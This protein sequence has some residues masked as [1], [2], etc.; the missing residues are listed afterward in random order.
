MNGRMF[1]VFAGIMGVVAA[2][3]SAG[4]GPR[5]Q[6]AVSQ[7]QPDLISVGQK[8]KIPSKILNETREVWI[9]LPP[10]YKDGGDRYPLLLQL[11]GE[12]NFLYS[13]AIVDVLS[14]NNHIPRIIVAALLDPTPRHH[15]RDS[16]PTKV[17]YLPASG[18]APQFLS[19]LKEEL[20]PALDAGFRTEPLR[21]LCGHG[22]SGLFS[23]SA[24]LESPGTFGAVLSDGASLSYDNSVFFK[25]AEAKLADPRLRGSLFLGVGNEL[26]TIPSNQALAALLTKKAPPSLSWTLEILN[27]ED[28]GTASLP[29]FYR[30]L[31]WL[32]RDWRLPVEVAGKGLDAVKAHNRALSEKMGFE[33]PVS[34]NTLSMRGFQLIREQR[35]GD[36]EVVFNLNASAYPES[37]N[38][39]QNLAFLSERMKQ[40][41]KAAAFYEKAAEK[42]A[43]VKPE[44]A[45]LFRMQAEQ[46]K[47]RIKSIRT[48]SK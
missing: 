3:A 26:E 46:A 14:K 1:A 37:P 9:A 10:G 39:Y 34:E 16:T 13:A 19:F 48:D 15:Y 43:A 18:G 42:A 21:I 2:T 31:K 29:V 44:L 36:A 23:I 30:G 11:G 35:F 38:V 20:I 32:F 5:A 12:A 24:L 25:N 17:D 47:R 28:Q 8:I 27:D 41:E 22:L 33:I 6:A 4:T 7:D 45:P 40:W